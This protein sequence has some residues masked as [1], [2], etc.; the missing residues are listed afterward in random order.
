[1][2]HITGAKECPETTH[3]DDHKKGAHEDEDSSEM[4]S[5][6]GEGSG[7]MYSADEEGSGEMYSAKGSG[8]IKQVEEVF[9]ED[10]AAEEKQAP[11]IVTNKPQDAAK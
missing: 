8:E 7:E 2:D 11:Q 10:A 3:G 9:G 6:K 1:M 4:Y 5:A